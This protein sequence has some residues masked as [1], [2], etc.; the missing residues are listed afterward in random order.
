MASDAEPQ[1]APEKSEVRE[2]GEWVSQHFR[3][4]DDAV[5]NIFDGGA[6]GA[7]P[8]ATPTTPKGAATASSSSPSLNLFKD[9]LASPAKAAAL[10]AS[11]A[12]VREEKQKALPSDH[13]YV[14]VDAKEPTPVVGAGKKKTFFRFCPRRN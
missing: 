14:S 12:S 9:V 4:L 11:T 13:D 2:S 3:S 5:A 1:E 6:Q 8:G 10:A 7:S